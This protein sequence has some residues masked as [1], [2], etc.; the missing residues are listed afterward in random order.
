MTA[1]D[2]KSACDEHASDKFLAALGGETEAELAQFRAM[3]KSES[4]TIAAL[5]L[6]QTFVSWSHGGELLFGYPAT[7]MVG[8]NLSALVAEI[9]E[10]L[11]RLGR[12]NARGETVE[13]NAKL[14]N[15]HGHLIQV[16]L[17][18]SPMR[19]HAGEVVGTAMI[20]V[21]GVGPGRVPRHASRVRRP[22]V[23]IV[24]DDADLCESFAEVL[25]EVALDVRCARGAAQ[26][27]QLLKNER[28]DVL[29]TDQCMPVTQGTELLEQAAQR[30]PGTARILFTG[31]ASTDLVIEAINRGRVRKVLLKSMHPVA[32]R[33]EIATVAH[34]VLH[35]YAWAG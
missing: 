15:V 30:F 23:L 6:N 12:R 34:E 20:I 32:I 21:A 8:R 1:S 11:A 3:M 17:T 9:N 29:V 26:A 22:V 13:L 4:H 31:H 10:P 16:V 33:D 5:D 35:R 25:S 24:D 7:E 28:V 2:E 19:N 14:R 18:T 27:L